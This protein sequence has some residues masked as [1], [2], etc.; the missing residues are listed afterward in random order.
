MKLPLRR[1]AE[2]LD[3][4]WLDT[5]WLGLANTTVTVD[6][7]ARLNHSANW[8]KG[9]FIEAYVTL[10]TQRISEPPAP[11]PDRQNEWSGP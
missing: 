6:S 5:G 11:F 7:V 4:E 1:V 2:W 3:A 8:R 9:S 10:Y